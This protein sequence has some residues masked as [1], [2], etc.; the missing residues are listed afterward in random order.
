MSALLRD[1]AADIERA[2]RAAGRQTG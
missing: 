2:L 1:T